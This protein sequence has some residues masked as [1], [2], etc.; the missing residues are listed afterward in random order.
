MQRKAGGCGSRK[1]Q[2]RVAELENDI[3]IECRD[4]G[5]GFGSQC[6]A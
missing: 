6:K 4:E 3:L 2:D 1:R 5:R